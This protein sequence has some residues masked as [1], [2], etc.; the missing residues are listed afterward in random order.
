M[1]CKREVVRSDACVYAKKLIRLFHRITDDA[2]V[3]QKTFMAFV[4]LIVNIYR[5]KLTKNYQPN[6]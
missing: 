4:A 2:P 3:T 6:P 1:L 5:V